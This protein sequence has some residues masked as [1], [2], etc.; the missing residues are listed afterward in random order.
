MAN[1]PIR[2]IH[3][4]ITS[5]IIIKQGTN[6][7][8]CANSPLLKFTYKRLINFASTCSY[9]ITELLRPT[10]PQF[11]ITLQVMRDIPITLFAVASSPFTY[12]T[13]KQS[14]SP[15]GHNRS[16]CRVTEYV[17]YFRIEFWRVCLP[18][19]NVPPNL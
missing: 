17:F 12:A 2:Y 9:Y 8:V 4:D 14:Y 18:R 1:P 3:L 15:Y 7:N 13:V 10:S 11:G 6:L 16:L 5:R 19:R